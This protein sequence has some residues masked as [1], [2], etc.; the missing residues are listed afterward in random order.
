MNKITVLAGLQWGDE[1]KGKIVDLLS[2]QYDVVARY[3]GGANAGHTL[4]FNGK[5]YVL[6]L[7]PSGIFTDGVTCIIGNGTVIDPE[8]L[9]EEMELISAEKIVLNGRL[10]ISKDAHLILPYH[11]IIDA[12]NEKGKNKI[13]TTK[14]G[15][16]P[17][18]F[19]K[20]ARRGIKIQDIGHL[21]LLKEKININLVYFKRI[22]PE[23]EELKNLTCDKVCEELLIRY[24]KIESFIGDTQ[25]L[26]HK[27]I[28][29]GRNILL[30]GAQGALLDVDFGTYPY[31]TSS[32]PTSGGAC[33]GTGIPPNKINNV[34][35]IFKAYTTRVGEG[36]FIT[37]LFDDDGKLIAQRG[38]EFGATTGRPRRCGWLDLV[39]LRYACKINGVTELVITKSD[40][41]DVF[42]EISVCTKYI[43]EGKEIS[44]FTTDCEILKS[45]EPLYRKFN[46]WNADL[47]QFSDYDSLPENYKNYIRFIEEYTGCKI[48]YVSTGPSREQIIKKI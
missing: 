18:Y 29:E 38:N 26:I 1:G 6:H 8:A 35:G 28:E 4:V 20:Y 45:V 16:G 37:E 14:K 9:I 10:F 42:P 27:F 33:V 46:G 40:V 32:H 44:D 5:K 13:G 24:G 12:I 36:P 43:I 17:S 39:A 23:S 34:V 3:Q 30:E 48:S 2:P 41:L 21:D 7:I 47:N 25:I 15:I 19:D 22:F 11:K 31:I